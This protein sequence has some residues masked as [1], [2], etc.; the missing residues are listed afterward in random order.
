MDLRQSTDA[1]IIIMQ[2]EA[3]QRLIIRFL[4]TA[5]K[6]VLNDKCF[7]LINSHT[8]SH[9]CTHTQCLPA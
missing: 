7:L 3:T 9:A 8:H 1:I 4:I 5:D 2:K 6:I